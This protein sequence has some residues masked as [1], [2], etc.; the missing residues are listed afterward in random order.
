VGEQTHT[1]I[2]PIDQT[3][4][5]SVAEQGGTLADLLGIAAA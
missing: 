4:L 1:S 3:R 5:D 2:E